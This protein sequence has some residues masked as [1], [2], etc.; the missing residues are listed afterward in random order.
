M[1]GA[2][3]SQTQTTQT[4]RQFRVVHVDD[5]DWVL[6]MVG[7]VIDR[8]FSNVVV[9]R[10]QNGDKA[11]RNLLQS[12][13]DLLITDLFNNNVPGRKEDHGKSGYELLSLL[14]QKNVKY[15]I[16]VISGSLAIQDTLQKVRQLA[17]SNLNIKFLKKPFTPDELCME[18]SKYIPPPSTENISKLTE[19]QKDIRTQ[20]LWPRTENVF[21][22]IQ[23]KGFITF[24]R[25][26][27]S[28]IVTCVINGIGIKMDS[29][30]GLFLALAVPITGLLWLIFK[31]SDNED[32]GDHM[33]VGEAIGILLVGAVLSFLSGLPVLLTF[34]FLKSFFASQ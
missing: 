8:K 34:A 10:F 33:E 26:L 22:K 31:I 13:P 14:T 9:R 29:G 30:T 1:T 11:W 5:E 19:E 2:D 25:C 16:L 6:G 20:T 21:P 7:T 3:H 28:G 18:L 15:P 24:K 12:D 4:T 27:V 32:T 23:K 17:D